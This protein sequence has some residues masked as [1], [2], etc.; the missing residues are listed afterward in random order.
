MN[1]QKLL[2][3]AAAGAVAYF[4]LMKYAVKDPESGQGFIPV[5]DGFGLDDVVL[6]GGAALA[7]CWAAKMA[8]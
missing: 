3:G 7:G 8:G 2:V 6:G 5:S 4:L 1:M